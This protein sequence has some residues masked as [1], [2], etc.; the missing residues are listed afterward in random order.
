M[1]DVAEAVNVGVGFT[2]TVNVPE[3]A[4]VHAPFAV[5]TV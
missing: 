2:V 3:G 5:V 1:A 4:L